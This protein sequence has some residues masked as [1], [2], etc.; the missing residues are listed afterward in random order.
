MLAYNPVLVDERI[1]SKDLAKPLGLHGIET[2][3]THLDFGDIAFLGRGEQD[4]TRDIGVELKTLGDCISSLRTGR[5]AGHQL[6][7]LVKSFDY[8][9]L[10][11]EGYWRHDEQGRIVTFQG[12]D[13]GWRA[14]SGNM[15]ATELEKQLLTLEM[16]SGLHV[17]FTNSRR[18]TIRF[19]ASLYRWWTDRDLDSHR[20][21]LRVHHKPTLVPISPERRTL[22]TLPGVGIIASA[23]IEKYFIEEGRCNLLRAFQTAPEVWADILIGEKRLGT[24]AAM[25]IYNFV[26][27][28][29]A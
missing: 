7:G 21:H 27:G 5:L 28:R 17:R 8:V 20:S 29:K 1:G 22:T 26:R 24:K 11:V 25:K 6:P 16:Q 13:R 10:V 3:I 12:K 4:C 23:A 19:L 18:D 2:E 15:L 14:A 9:W